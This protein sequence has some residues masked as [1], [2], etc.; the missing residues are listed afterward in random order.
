MNKVDKKYL[1][2][3][4]RKVKQTISE[5]KLIN[6]KDKVIV[7]LSGGKDSVTTLYLLKKL[8]YRVEALMIDLL[9]GKWSD[10][11]LANMDKFCSDLGIKLHVLNMRKEFGSSICYIRQGIQKKEKLTNCMICGVIKRWILNKYS[12]KLGA[13]KIATGHNL[14]DEA[15]T[16]LM[17]LLKGNYKLISSMGPKTG[18]INDKKF[19]QRIK[20]LYFL[21]NSE[22]RKFSEIMKFPVLYQSCPCLIGTFR[23]RIREQLVE[24]EKETKNIKEKIVKN[25]LKLKSKVKIENPEKVDYCEICQEPSRNKICKR[26]ELIKILKK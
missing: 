10:D 2:N 9:I 22:I 3:I 12:R 5:Y 1:A 8:G 4:E 16:V 25:F 14:D 18:I 6:K 21:Q 13:S 7:A 19:V 24:L 23:K 11:H 20:P 17:N 26:C 15:E